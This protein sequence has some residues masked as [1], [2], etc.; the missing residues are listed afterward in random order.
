MWVYSYTNGKKK[1]IIQITKFNNLK[2]NIMCLTTKSKEPRLAKRDMA[3]LKYVRKEGE[4]YTSPCQGTVIPI[5]KTMYPKSS[6][7]DLRKNWV[8]VKGNET[9][10]LF[11][12]VIHARITPINGLG[13]CCVK[14]IIPKGTRFWIDPALQEI[15]AEQMIITDEEIK[16]IPDKNLFIEI[17]ATAPEKNGVRVGDYQLEDNTFVHP[18]DNT[19]DLNP[20]GIV[21]GFTPDDKPLVCAVE[22]LSGV[23]DKQWNSQFGDFLNGDREEVTTKF[24]GKEITRKYAESKERDASRFEAFEKCIN[25]RKDKNEEWYF[26]AI[27]EMLE[28]IN[29]AE[30]INAA[31]YITG[32]GDVIDYY[33]FWSCSEYDSYCSLYCCLHRSGVHCGWGCKGYRYRI[34]PFFAS[35]KEP[36]EKKK[37][38]SLKGI[39]S[40]IWKK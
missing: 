7:P 5:N 33:W 28:L 12:G 9:Q 34:V 31:H 24:N 37:T 40:K 35:T 30:Y 21:C 39:I 4:E 22:I 27:G 17:L 29:N 8:D 10:D 23:W 16:E 26:G 11:G 32:I 36:K 3:V 19:K 18:T 6:V 25:Y 15:A 1:R 13:N 38:N 20:R 14:A 2:L